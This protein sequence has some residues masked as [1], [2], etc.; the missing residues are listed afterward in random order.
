MLPKYYG[1]TLVGIRVSC[2]SW[3]HSAKLSVTCE[4]PKVILADYLDTEALG[5][6]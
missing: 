6:Y 5:V 2:Y 3:L 1:T 4:G